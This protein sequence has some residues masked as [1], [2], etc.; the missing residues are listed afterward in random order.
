MLNMARMRREFF[1]SAGSFTLRGIVEKWIL[2]PP[3]YWARWVRD[4]K[5]D[6]EAIHQQNGLNPSVCVRKAAGAFVG[7]SR[8]HPYSVVPARG[9][10]SMG[11]E[12]RRVG[13][14]CR[15]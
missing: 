5:G 1:C 2:L 3:W 12:E 11:S 13:K 8:K 6:W 7:H 9:F 14:E 10:S 15:S 4:T